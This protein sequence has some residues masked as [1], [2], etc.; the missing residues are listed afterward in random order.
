MSSALATAREILLR[1]PSLINGRAASLRL[2]TAREKCTP[3]EATESLERLRTANQIAELFKA[4]MPEEFARDQGSLTGIAKRFAKALGFPINIWG[5]E[6]SLMRGRHTFLNGIPIESMSG[7]VCE[8]CCQFNYLPTLI[9]LTVLLFGTSHDEMDSMV[10]LDPEEAAAW[11]EEKE[12]RWDLLA[13][14][15]KLPEDLRPTEEVADLWKVYEKERSPI[16]H[17]PLLGQMLDYNTGCVFFDFNPEDLP[18]DLDWT[19][20]N[21]V[22]LR[23]EYKRAQ[24]IDKNLGRLS[25]WFYANPRERIVKA[26]RLY[27]QAAKPTNGKTRKPRIPNA[28]RGTLVRIL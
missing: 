6:H 12:G 10:F 2:L 22:W 14:E 26:L 15:H 23:A 19:Q 25:D 20:A 13:K 17:L 8:G 21:V 7:H 27:K 1:R 4:V 24:A 9:Q 11:K 16:Q 3:E 28:A 5:I 18:P